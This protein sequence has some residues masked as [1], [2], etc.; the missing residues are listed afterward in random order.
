M[1]KFWHYAEGYGL[2]ILL[3]AA[4]MQMFT[5]WNQGNLIEGEFWRVNQRLRIVFECLQDRAPWEQG[6]YCLSDGAYTEWIGLN[7]FD[8]LY[9]KQVSVF[10]WVYVS[11]YFFGSALFIA[12]RFVA[13]SK[14][15]K[16]H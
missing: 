15:D 12:A 13:L 9:E 8:H 16:N 2:A 7:N 10:N 4:G 1:K 3:L 14:E 11:L 5:L 6:S